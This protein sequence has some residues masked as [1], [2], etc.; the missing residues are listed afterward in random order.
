[1]TVK[2]KEKVI[3]SSAGIITA[4]LLF[5]SYG[6]KLPI[7]EARTDAYFQESITK[8]GIA[9]AT[10]RIINAS[11]S[12]VKD[13]YL[14]LEPA[15]IG[16]S[17]AV[18]QA[19]DP[20]DDMAE[21]LSDVLVTAIT[22]LGVQKL[23]YEISVA[24]APPVLAIFILLIS[25]LMLFKNERLKSFR[26]VLIKFSLFVMIVRFCLPVSSIAN[27][28]IDKH[29][30]SDQVSKARRELAMNSAKID[31]LNDFSLPK[32]D[33]VLGIIGSSGSFIKRKSTELKNSFFNAVSNMG[34]IIENLLK[35]TFLYVGMFMIQVVILPLLSF[36]FLIK[37]A[38]ALF[39]A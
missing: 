10:C 12:I 17:L 30:F 32:I 21:R 16:I 9:Y 3:K 31:E 38:N 8:T 25:I 22:S 19:L 37:I 24:L 5:F 7:M 20:I 29:F 13:S 15:G 4:I 39:Y 27:D 36:W 2:N 1:M 14:Q 34:D 35:L 11:V 23:V 6:L 26:K 28:F 18:G 33:G